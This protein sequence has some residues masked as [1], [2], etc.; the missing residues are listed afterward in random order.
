[1]LFL[2]WPFNWIIS[3]HNNSKVG[4]F[5]SSIFVELSKF[6]LGFSN[7]RLV[8]KWQTTTDVKINYP[9]MHFYWIKHLSRRLIFWLLR[10]RYGSSIRFR[11][12]RT[13]YGKMLWSFSK[14]TLRWCKWNAD[15]AVE[16]LQN[17]SVSMDTSSKGRQFGL[18][19]TT[20]N[21]I[22]GIVR[23]P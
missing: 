21:Q 22:T 4:K 6:L 15:Y 17:W 10:N 14:W 3:F 11:F 23:P 9:E 5:L 12:A 16:S 2:N 13:V 18:R 19:R 1:M 20:A 8:R 7:G